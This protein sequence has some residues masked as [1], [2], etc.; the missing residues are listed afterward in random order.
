MDLTG[1]TEVKIKKPSKDSPQGYRYYFPD[2][3]E[4]IAQTCSLCREILP[5][6]M[7]SENKTKASGYNSQCRSCARIGKPS[8]SKKY[9]K[10]YVN[11]AATKTKNKYTDRTPKMVEDTRTEM[12]PDGLK[13]CV[14]CSTKKSINDF[15]NSKWSKDGL[16]TYCKGCTKDRVKNK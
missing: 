14:D 6:Q 9:G 5:A 15:Y 8:A 10:E 12:Y 16:T 11:K 1:L 7:F 3:D 2:S 13:L 4:I